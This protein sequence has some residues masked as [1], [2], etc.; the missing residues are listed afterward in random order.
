M[1]ENLGPDKMILNVAG[2]V[3]DTFRRLPVIVS[4]MEKNVAT[5]TKT[6]LKL[7]SDTIQNISET[8]IKRTAHINRFYII[9]IIVLL[10]LLVLN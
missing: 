7:N 9:I 5:I 6:G 10:G 1:H 3:A 8:K 2:E 4:N